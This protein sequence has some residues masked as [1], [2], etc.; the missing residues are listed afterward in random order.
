MKKLKLTLILMTVALMSNAQGYY[1]H[2]S[3]GNKKLNK[4]QYA[5][6]EEIFKKGI[7]QDSSQNELYV[8]L[9]HAL[10]SQKKF[11][12]ADSFLDVVLERDSVNAG[13]TWFK[14]LGHYKARNDSLSV[15]WFKNF[16]PLAKPGDRN[17]R[18]VH[19][20]IGFAYFHWLKDEGLTYS[21]TNDM[22]LEMRKYIRMMP[23][24]QN[25]YLLENLIEKIRLKRPKGKHGRWVYKEDKKTE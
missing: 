11:T 12:E 20:Y 21:Q 14:G 24:D 19:W 15:V 6:A 9:G 5:E 23:D 18:L 4:G 2:Y 22:I 17:N 16:V 8:Q 25:N 1:N 7:D 13:A 3:E 10:I